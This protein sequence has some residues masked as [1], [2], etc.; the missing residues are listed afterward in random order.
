MSPIVGKD[1]ILQFFDGSDYLD[2]VCITECSIEWNTEMQEVRTINGG[3]AREIRP[4]KDSGVINASGVIV[5]DGG[6]FKAFDLLQEY[7]LQW[8]P[9]LWQMLFDSPET[10][11]Q[12]I[13]RGRSYIERSTFTGPSSGHSIADFTLPID[14]DIEV[15]DSIV[16]CS[17]TIGNLVAGFDPDTGNTTVTY[18][19]VSGA[20]RLEYSV[21][22]GDRVPVF[23][24]GT[25]GLFYIPGL[26]DGPHT[27]QVWTVCENGIDGEDNSVIF[28]VSGG[29]PGPTCALPGMPEMSDLTGTTGT[30]TWAAASP[31]PAGGYFWEVR[32]AATGVLFSSGYTS[33]LFT[34]LTGLIDGV[35]Y[36]FQV[37]SLCEE[38]VSESSY[39]RVDFTSEAPAVCNVPGTP[40]MSAISTSVATA[41]W[42]APSPAPGSGYSWQLL[43]GVTVVDSGT[44]GSLSVNLTGLSAE[45]SY[46][47]RVKAICGVGSESGYN[48]VNFDT[49][50]EPVSV[51]SYDVTTESPRVIITLNAV[52]EYN[53]TNNGSGTF[54]AVGGDTVGISAAGVS[55]SVV[56]DDTTSS[57]NIITF[58]GSGPYSNSFMVT[59]GHNYTV[60]INASN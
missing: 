36:Y 28:E 29:E 55:V 56:V 19:G 31:S 30:A 48:S 52:D 2:F 27:V 46:T 43:Q 18:D 4:K 1:V 10:G 42:T 17:A 57:T 3:R 35:D 16:G 14:G 5:L 8:L 20:D 51:I 47:F 54:D 58:S 41:T 59:T 7:Q 60:T 37:K 32:Y 6:R 11:L 12:K 40:V 26:S 50:S 24:P 45:T 38:G 21:D 13:V 22:G 49:L 25:S 23:S 9:L 53:D 44:T 15:L 33:D 39:Q 34:N